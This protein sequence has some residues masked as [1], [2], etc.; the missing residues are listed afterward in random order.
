MQYRGPRSAEIGR[1]A[2]L[3]A[4]EEQ[5]Q[6]LGVADVQI[7][8]TSLE[9]VFLTIAREAEREAA[10]LAGDSQ[11]TTF[12]DDGTKLKVGASRTLFKLLDV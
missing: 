4:L 2:F 5:K 10:E 7:S 3:A 8:L 9:E 11:H 6:A 12:L 1:P